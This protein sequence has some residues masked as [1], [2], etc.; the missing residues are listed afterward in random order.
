[1]DGVVG[2]VK[3]I[4]RAEERRAVV[5]FLVLGYGTESS[6]RWMGEGFRREEG[7]TSFIYLAIYCHS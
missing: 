4:G 1:M 3:L 6:T 7:R 5:G 2:E